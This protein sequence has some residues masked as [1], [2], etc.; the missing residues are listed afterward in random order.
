MG[1]RHLLEILNFESGS[2]PSA[3]LQVVLIYPPIEGLLPLT[4]I[5]PTPFWNSSSKAAELQVYA[6]TPG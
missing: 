4:G 6:T 3:R 1:K 5:E 2:S